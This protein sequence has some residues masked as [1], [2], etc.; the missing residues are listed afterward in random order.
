MVCVAETPPADTTWVQA[1]TLAILSA[2]A[3]ERG[4]PDLTLAWEHH[5]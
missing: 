4:Q 3:S 5:S 2:L 1:P